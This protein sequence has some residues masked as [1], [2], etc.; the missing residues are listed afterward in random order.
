MSVIDISKYSYDLVINDEYMEKLNALGEIRV[1]MLQLDKE[2]VR[3]ENELKD[4]NCVDECKVHKM[5]R[6]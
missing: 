2:R 3:L 6:D 4:M 1:Q 5:D